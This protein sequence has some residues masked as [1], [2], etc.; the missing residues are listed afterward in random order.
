MVQV[1]QIRQIRQIRIQ[2]YGGDRVNAGRGPIRY[3]AVGAEDDQIT[4]EP[5]PGIP[6]DGVGEIYS[7]V[8][9]YASNIKRTSVSGLASTKKGSKLADLVQILAVCTNAARS[10]EAGQRRILM[11]ESSA[12]AEDPF[13]PLV[14]ARL[15]RDIPV[16]SI[17]SVPIKIVWPI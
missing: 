5:D 10:T 11:S 2:S 6:R 3:M 7:A 12:W 16:T 15:F 17:C 9:R 1:K 13:K 8:L 4:A 14:T